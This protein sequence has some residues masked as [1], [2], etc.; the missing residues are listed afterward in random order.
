MRFF[1]Q[2]PE[3][4]SKYSSMNTMLNPPGQRPSQT[5]E[6]FWLYH[7]PAASYEHVDVGK[8]MLFYDRAQLDDAWMRAKA[9]LD[10]GHLPGVIRMKTS[11]SRENDRASSDGGVLIFYCSHSHDESHIQQIGQQILDS[12]LHTSSAYICYKTDVQTHAGTC[13]TGNTTNS[14]YRRK[15]PHHVPVLETRA[16]AS[17]RVPTPMES[18]KTHCVACHYRTKNPPQVAVLQTRACATCGEPTRIDSW[19]TRCGACYKQATGCPTGY[20]F[21]DAA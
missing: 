4:T 8:W 15:N 21:R 12:M 2:K 19:K 10:A 3:K 18:W 5:A 14:T 16:C 6:D 13:A 17:C 1:N 7:Q 9:L 11:T 20:R